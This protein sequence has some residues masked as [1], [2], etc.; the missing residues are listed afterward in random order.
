[1]NTVADEIV[2]ML[3]GGWYHAGLTYYFHDTVSVK[4]STFDTSKENPTS[5][6][7]ETDLNKKYFNEILGLEKENGIKNHTRGTPILF[8]ISSDNYS[9]MQ[10]A[11]NFLN[12]DFTA[13]SIQFA[14]CLL[15]NYINL[16]DDLPPLNPPN[17]AY[18]QRKMFWE[19]D[20]SSPPEKSITYIQSTSKL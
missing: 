9:N 14:E 18:L 7:E 8:P 4:G 13:L 11:A 2:K 1:M 16:I 19:D 10:R 5:Y 12:F 15:A 3:F 20:A 17:I 6:S